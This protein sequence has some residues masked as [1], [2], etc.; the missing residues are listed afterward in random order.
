MKDTKAILLKILN[1]NTIFNND[2]PPSAVNVGCDVFKLYPSV[3]NDMG[4]KAV[5]D[6]LEMYPNPD[7]LPIDFILELGAICV[8]ENS[9]EF[10]EKFYCPNTGTATGPP[11]ACD[12]VDIFMG[13][14]DK[15][16]VD[17]LV[18]KGVNTTDWTLY[19]DDGWM[20]P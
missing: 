8:E 1:I 16:V 11:H 13:E 10:K 4:L 2:L 15:V 12:Y 6:N 14:L 9:C 18:E 19:R 3:D 17:K 5:K 7:G 20:I